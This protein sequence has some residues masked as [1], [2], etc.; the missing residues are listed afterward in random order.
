MGFVL[1]T[2]IWC[3]RYETVEKLLLAP[4]EELSYQEKEKL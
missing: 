1:M 4:A 2:C 3:C